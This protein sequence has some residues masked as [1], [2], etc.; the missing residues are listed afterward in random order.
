MSKNVFYTDFLK[1]WHGYICKFIRK[2]ALDLKLQQL[3]SWPSSILLPP[4]IFCPFI[5]FLSGWVFNNHLEHQVI[6]HT[7]GQRGNKAKI[8]V[9]YVLLKT[10]FYVLY[11]YI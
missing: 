7:F 9:F 6:D 5:L 4:P 10:C 8:P 2:E 1:A 11:L 3:W